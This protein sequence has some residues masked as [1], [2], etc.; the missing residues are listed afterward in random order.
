MVLR[1][2]HTP[3]SPKAYFKF[4]EAKEGLRVYVWGKFI[5]TPAVVIGGDVCGTGDVW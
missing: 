1:L 2:E 4:S 5:H 3:D